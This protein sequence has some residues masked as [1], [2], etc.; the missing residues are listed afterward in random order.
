V[1]RALARTDAEPR[2][3]AHWLQTGEPASLT[4]HA[5]E[6]GTLPA[7]T[8]KQIIRAVGAAG[9]R[10]RGGAWFPTG[11]K[12]ASVAD[13]GA[14]AG[15][16]YVVVNG[17][18]GEPASAKDKL[19]LHVAPH[20]V[21]DGAEL[22]AVAVGARQVTVCL[23]RDAAGL[24]GLRAAIAE[25]RAAGWG[26]SG[27]RLRVL[28]SPRWYVSSDSS[29][30][31]RFVE[32]GPAKPRDEPTHVQGVKGQ[33]TLVSNVETLAHLAL[34]TRFGAGWFRQAGTV[35]S[36]GTWLVTLSGAVARP[37]VYEIPV[38][39]SA[40][41]LLRLAGGASSPWQAMLLGGYAGSW[42]PVGETLDMPLA[43]ET[44][45][46]TRSSLGPG[47]LIGLP[48]AGCGLAETARVVAWLAR[49]SA[50]QCGPCFKGTPTIAEEL[51]RLTWDQ[52]QR[53]LHRLRYAMALVYRRGACSY[54]DGVVTLT[55][56]A[57]RV[58]AVD[59]GRHLATGRCSGSGHPRVLPLP[60]ALPDTEPWR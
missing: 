42:L 18:E 1:T 11:R 32:G 54:P 50:R 51:S 56:S 46:A 15:S 38:G 14:E 53:A 39:T 9:L 8:G 33:P 16:T 37:G 19:L 17:A 25:R 48:S 20:L 13:H 21:L 4:D 41:E 47:I 58:F 2:L 36:P 57:L 3:L 45:G 6:Y 34:I 24:P 59:I 10:G 7:D 26:R 12:L 52:D 44:L 30:L 27:V 55:E 43:P 49:Q 35:K 31:A 29:A 23:H 60:A 28:E 22:A 40:A 5:R